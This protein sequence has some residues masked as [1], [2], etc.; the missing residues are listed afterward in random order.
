MNVGEELILTQNE[1]DDFVVIRK[2][3]GTCDVVFEFEVK[4]IIAYIGDQDLNLGPI[5]DKDWLV[6]PYMKGSIKWD[7]CANVMFNDDGY[8]HFCGQRDFERHNALIR[9]LYE[10]AKDSV[11]MADELSLAPWEKEIKY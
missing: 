7:G 11:E 2:G 5:S 4:R 3:D 10:I 8:M 1:C 6:E 9:K